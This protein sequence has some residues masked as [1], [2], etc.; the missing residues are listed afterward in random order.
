MKRYIVFIAGICLLT[1]GAFAADDS[2]AWKPLFNGKNLNGWTVHYASKVAEGSPA[3]SRF[4]KVEDGAIHVYANEA[5]GT[6]Q[7]NAILVS[8][9]D[10][11]DY[12]ISLEYKW[13]EKK[14]APRLNVVRDAGLLY[15]LHRMRT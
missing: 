14:F 13:G 10:L 8:D 4:F 9:G 6:E 3:P 11:K 15:N 7:P 5:A 1:G 12:K 2:A